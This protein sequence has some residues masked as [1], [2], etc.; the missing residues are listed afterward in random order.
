MPQGS[1]LGPLLFLIYIN[2]MVDDVQSE[3]FLYADDSMLLE[4]VESPTDSAEKNNFDLAS[5]ANWANKWDVIM[6][7]SKSR[8]M[9]FSAKREKPPHPHLL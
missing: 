4:I 6:N 9:V 7:G 5:I 2:D 3:A 1:V 8:S